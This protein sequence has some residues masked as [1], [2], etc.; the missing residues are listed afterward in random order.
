MGEADRKYARRTRIGW[1]QLAAGIGAAVLL[2]VTP[3]RAAELG[4][5]TVASFDHY[6]QLTEAQITSQLR[7]GSPFLWVD[8]L[9]ESR[10]VAAYAQLR[11]GQ[12]TIERLETL[13]NGQPLEVPHGLVHH[14]IGTIFVPDATLAQTLAIVEDYD[15]HSDYYKPDVMRSRI[16]ERNGN[17]FRIYLR[18][19]KR[20]VLTSVLDTEHEVRYTI[21]DATHAWS[22]SRSTHIREV[23]DPGES[24]EQW[25]PEGHDRGLLWRIYTHWRFEQKDGGIYIECQSISLTRDIPL[26]L[27]W[28]IGP[29]VMSVPRESLTFTLGATRDAL[30]RESKRSAAQK[31]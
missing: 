18:F 6:A 5:Q 16:L 23:Q 3:L 29:Y 30:L 20:K 1:R 13:E 31:H 8:R 15:H 22:R 17:D 7:D 19:H 12:A 25:K 11:Q 10:R 28:L 14:W 2:A 4:P 27:G 26:G 24:D 9:P 21:V